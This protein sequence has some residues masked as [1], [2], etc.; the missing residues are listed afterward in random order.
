MFTSEIF[1]RTALRTHF[2]FSHEVRRR[3]T[4]S[5]PSATFT[6]V[7]RRYTALRLG[8]PQQELRV[9]ITRTRRDIYVWTFAENLL[10]YQS[11]HHPHAILSLLYFDYAASPPRV[12]RGQITLVARGETVVRV[13]VCRDILVVERTDEH[14]VGRGRTNFIVSAECYRLC[15]SGDAAVAATRVSVIETFEFAYIDYSH[16][17][18][19]DHSGTYYAAYSKSSGQDSGV[20]VWE[21]ATG[22]KVKRIAPAMLEGLGGMMTELLVVREGA[23]HKV[24]MIGNDKRNNNARRWDRFPGEWGYLSSVRIFSIDGDEADEEPSGFVGRAKSECPRNANLLTMSFKVPRLPGGLECADTDEAEE[25]ALVLWELEDHTDRATA[26]YH[27]LSSAALSVRREPDTPMEADKQYQIES[28]SAETG[29]R[30]APF[31]VRTRDAMSFMMDFTGRNE[32]FEDTR[33]MVY[34]LRIQAFYPSPTN[35]RVMEMAWDSCLKDMGEP[36]KDVSRSNRYAKNIKRN[37]FSASRNVSY[38]N[39]YGMEVVGD[40]RAVAFLELKEGGMDL[41][42]VV[43]DSPFE[44]AS[45]EQTVGGPWRS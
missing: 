21:I 20:G 44:G 10:V 12:R 3:V 17:I 23:V 45:P 43:W 2:P 38:L 9:P 1:L 25:A 13:R 24:V 22:K 36:G 16:Q 37:V 35:P 18:L 4:T 8:T 31:A 29:L 32:G 5:P 39:H 6:R 28:Q 33:L 14:A 11:S 26:H 7:A 19:S 40:E 34:H 30:P 41:V 27:S 15:S 42:I